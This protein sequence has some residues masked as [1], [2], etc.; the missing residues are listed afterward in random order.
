VLLNHGAGQTYNVNHPSYSGGKGR[1]KI[2]M[3]L[4]PGPHSAEATRRALPNATVIEVGVAKLDEWHA[5]AARNKRNARPVVAVAFHWRCKVAPETMSAVDDYAE[6]L[7]A[8][9][10]DGRWQVIGHGHPTAWAE[11]KPMWDGLGVEA[12]EDFDE[13]L[14]RADVFVVDNSSTAFEFASTGRPVLCLNGA[15]YRRDIEHGLRFWDAVPGLDIWPDDDLCDAVAMTLT[16]PPEAQQRRAHA[17]SRAYVACDGN[18]ADRAAAALVELAH[19]QSAGIVAATSLYGTVQVSRKAWNL[20]ADGVLITN[21][22]HYM[23]V[24]RSAYQE[25]WAAAGW[26][27]AE[28]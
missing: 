6:Q 23:L 8:L 5:G 9:V 27:I 19:I 16:D 28:L 14:R 3:F 1:D 17:V 21:Q 12:V 26:R 20:L 4:E 24:T 11:L 7:A 13:V 10:A 25:Q 2:A 15:D 22:N 18:A